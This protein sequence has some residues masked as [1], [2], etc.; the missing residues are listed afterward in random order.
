MGRAVA[1]ITIPGIK[2]PIR[3]DFFN[4]VKE[5]GIVSSE[6]ME[7]AGKKLAEK[8]KSMGVTRAQID[9]VDKFRYLESNAETKG[10]FGDW[11]DRQVTAQLG[12]RNF[13]LTN[14]TEGAPKV[15]KADVGPATPARPG[16]PDICAEQAKMTKN[17]IAD[18]VKRGGFSWS[19]DYYAPS[20]NLIDRVGMWAFKSYPQEY[21]GFQSMLTQEA[22]MLPSD[23]K[24]T[25]AVTKDIVGEKEADQMAF[26]GRLADAIKLTALFV[27]KLD[28][29]PSLTAVQVQKDLSS[30]TTLK[31]VRDSK[32]Y[33]R[34]LADGKT[35]DERIIAGLKSVK[36]DDWAKKYEAA[37]KA[38][39]DKKEL[40]A[41]DVK[42]TDKASSEKADGL[43]E[44]VANIAHVIK[45]WNGDL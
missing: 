38:L 27:E 25:T 15:E 39:G 28:A 45:W 31:L 18:A 41:K 24:V 9:A 35:M 34:K 20:D 8:L 16:D 3:T 17:C 6:E 32:L 22:L 44:G 40:T 2:D 10:F 7:L 37:V 26:Y 23:N 33:T 30:G 43:C 13:L 42:V 21:Q 4:G 14:F 11:K 19:D 12:V 29:I 36:K 1:E 5:D